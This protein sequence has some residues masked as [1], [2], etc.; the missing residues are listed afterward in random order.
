MLVPRH[1]RGIGVGAEVVVSASRS[2]D[3]ESEQLAR[4][5]VGANTAASG[6]VGGTTSHLGGP[7]RAQRDVR[8]PRTQWA[9]GGAVVQTVA[10]PLL[11]V[12]PDRPDPRS[13]LLYTSD[14]ADDLLCVDLGG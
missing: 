2:V 10:V 8:A 5:R 13:C 12:G 1:W 6:A 9:A 14:A 3:A 4:G 11:D 7:V